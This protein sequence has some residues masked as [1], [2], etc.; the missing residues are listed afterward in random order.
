[1]R[2]GYLGSEISF[3][4]ISETSGGRNIDGESLMI[5]GDLGFRI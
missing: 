2:I 1:M 3:H 5:S 4:N